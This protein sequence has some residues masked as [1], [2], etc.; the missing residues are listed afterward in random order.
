M[1]CARRTTS[2]ASPSRGACDH[3]GLPEVLKPAAHVKMPLGWK[4]NRVNA[5]FT[6]ASAM[7]AVELVVEEEGATA[8]QEARYLKPASRALILEQCIQ[9]RDRAVERAVPSLSAPDAK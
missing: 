7:R 2:T 3:A 4:G 5:A 8:V 1:R 6:T 9:D